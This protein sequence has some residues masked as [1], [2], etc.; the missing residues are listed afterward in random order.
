MFTH[1]FI[2]VYPL[3]YCH[4]GIYNSKLI[5]DVKGFEEMIWKSGRH[6]VQVVVSVE[7]TVVA[8][9]RLR[10]IFKPDFFNL[11]NT[12]IDRCF[13]SEHLTANG[14]LVLVIT[15]KVFSSDSSSPLKKIS[16]LHNNNEVVKLNSKL[17]ESGSYSDFTFNVH[18]KKFKVHRGILAAASPVFDKMFSA[19]MAES[20]SKQCHVKDIKPQVFKHLLEFIYTGRVPG[21]ISDVAKELFEAAHYYEIEK[22]KEICKQ[23][24]PDML[25]VENAM[26]TYE[27]AWT[28]E[29]EELKLAAW[30]II[31]R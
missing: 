1:S 21:D 9:S 18:K 31:K 22:L 13:L 16:N 17:L 23:E 10:N 29:L 2:N 26:E 24:F 19:S 11:L 8:D 4:Q 30:K 27:W 5:V 15:I 6:Q 12:F 20:K 7:D 25:T 14:S 28:Y 3:R